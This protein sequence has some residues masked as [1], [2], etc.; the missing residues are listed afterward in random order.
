M[1]FDD[2]S[3]KNIEVAVIGGGS[4][5]SGMTLLFSSHGSNIGAFD[6]DPSVVKATLQKAASTKGGDTS[7]VHGFSTLQKLMAAFTPN[8]PRIVVFSLPH[9]GVVDEVLEEIG[10]LMSE[11]DLIVDGGNEQY[12]STERR[13]KWAKEEWG[14]KY[15]G[16]GVSGGYQAA[17][18]GPSMSAGGEREAYDIVEPL[19]KKWAAKTPSG[20]SCVGLVGPRGSGNF[21]KMIHNGIEQGHLSVFAEVR[22]LLRHQ[23]SLSNFE[24]ADIFEKW[25]AEGELRGNYLLNI[26]VKALKFTKG[27]GVE[28]E[29]GVVEGI[30]DK[31][32]QDVDNSE[33]TGVWTLTEIGTRHVAAPTIAAAHQLRIISADRGERLK[34]VKAL[35]IDQPSTAEGVKDVD[36]FVEVVRKA[37]YG[38]ILGGFVQGLALIARA[39]KDENWG[40]QLSECIRIW[41][42]GCIIQS[43]GIADFLEPLLQKSAN[44]STI[45]PLLVPE[46]AS[47]IS[48]T[49]SSLKEVAKLVLETDAVAPALSATLEWVK[50]VGGK[51]LPTNFEEMQLDTFG[52][53]RYDVK[54]EFVEGTEKGPYHTEFIPA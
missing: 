33:G 35:G 32:T 16:M 34:V 54:S 11:G 52:A 51:D 39:S 10:P 47:E 40:V 48:K 29:E 24:I 22:S 23:L 17:R 26:A 15:L 5:G 45:N 49:Y 20:D 4:M 36:A 3:I 6:K 14:V 42:A 21:V 2:E 50:A 1:S 38:A 44:T 28:N 53:H 46:I 43:D 7:L 27:D 37:T 18:R 25:S 8:K 9:G 19:L 12:R 13:Q 31:I 41:R 30:E